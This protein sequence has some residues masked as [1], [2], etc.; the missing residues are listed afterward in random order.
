MSRSITFDYSKG[1]VNRAGQ[2]LADG[3]PNADDIS[4]IENWRAAHNYI[5]NTFQASLRRKAKEKN[6]RPPVQRIKRLSTIKGK[7]T[8]YPN[9]QL[10]RM[11]DVVGCRVIFDN[12]IQLSDFRDSFNKS[13]FRHKRRV[14]KNENGETIEAYNYITNPKNS[15]YRGIHDVFEYQAKQGGAQRTSGGHR[16]N[17]LLIEI[18]YRT[19]VQHA[20]ATAVEIC[21][22]YTENHGKF[23]DAPQD[24]LRY[25]QLASEILARS[26]EA[27]YSCNPTLTNSELVKEFQELE[28]NHGM[29]R[30]LRGIQPS[31]P[32]FKSSKH[33]LL[34]HTE[35]LLE[36]ST[37]VR[38]YD[39]FKKA[40]SEYFR[41]ERETNSDVVLV[42]A[43]D[44]ESVRFGFKNYFSDA[45]EFV[46]LIDEGVQLLKLEAARE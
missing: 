36:S 11:H 1:K 34:I 20:W 14:K 12:I 17:G 28:A 32:E 21:D 4:V 16:W 30:T 2:R 23:N 3:I 37:Q 13:R 29:L 9:M 15:G 24:Y 31:D 35:D 33:T 10:A 7:L 6:V 45:T 42:A 46:R 19:L 5:L 40:V 38:T 26:H 18:Q 43:D 22:I 25:F 8:R 39:T 44:S 27:M 41:L